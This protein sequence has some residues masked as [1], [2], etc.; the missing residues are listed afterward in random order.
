MNDNRQLQE[1]AEGLINR[2][3]A[4][5]LKPDETWPVIAKEADAPMQVFLRYVVPLAAIGPIAS[6]IGGQVFGFGAF[7]ISYRPSFMGG[8]SQAITSYV[9]TLASIWLI[10]WVANF[11]S[12]KFEGKDD[13]ASAFKLAAYSMTAAWIAGIVGLVPSLAIL[14][15]AGLYS[16]YLFYKGAPTMMDVPKDKSVVYTAVTVV[17]AIIANIAIGAIA[18]AI[19]GPTA[20]TGAGGG[21]ITGENTTIDL[22]EYGSIRVDEDGNTT[23]ATFNVDGEEMTIETR[24]EGEE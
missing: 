22:G 6:F 17:V 10:A 16:L 23:T 19:A 24:T 21:T 9:L 12:P 8:L 5:T 2:A 3:K 11:L 14:G 4:V 18:T 15:L 13:F 7:G 1:R 20:L